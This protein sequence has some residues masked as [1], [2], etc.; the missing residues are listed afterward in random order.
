MRSGVEYRAFFPILC[1]VA[2]GCEDKDV[3]VVDVFALVLGFET[4]CTLGLSKVAL[5]KSI[6]CLRAMK[7]KK[8]CILLSVVAC[9][10][11]CGI[12]GLE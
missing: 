9:I 12:C 4:T 6:Q 7:L 5:Y 1:L 8:E 11:Y 2:I 3:D 10:V